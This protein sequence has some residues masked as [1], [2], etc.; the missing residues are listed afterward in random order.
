MGDG[1]NDAG[2]S[3]WGLVKACEDALRRLGT[4]YIDILQLHALASD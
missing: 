1:P 4:D 2:S 3:R